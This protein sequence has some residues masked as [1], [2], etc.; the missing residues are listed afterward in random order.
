MSD[1]VIDTQI[2]IWYFDN[3]S[4]LSSAANAALDGA[5]QHGNIIYLSTISIVEI[6]YL[7]EKGKIAPDK[8]LRLDAQLRL[9]NT[10]FAVQS[11]TKEISNMI[12][13][14]P[15]DIVPDMPDRIIAATALYL[16]APLISSDSEINKLNNIKVIW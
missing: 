8:L 3:S 16:D 4:R 12:G 14:I 5:V 2:A 1:I 13:L 10:S 6:T 7:I 11:L 15:R 9:P